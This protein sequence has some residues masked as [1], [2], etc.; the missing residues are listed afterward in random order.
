LIYLL[1]AG[2]VLPAMCKVIYFTAMAALAGPVN[3]KMLVLLKPASR[4]QALKSAAV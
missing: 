2:H 1:A 4:A 3:G